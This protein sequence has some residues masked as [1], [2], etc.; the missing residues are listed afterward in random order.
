MN[1]EQALIAALGRMQSKMAK[2]RKHIRGLLAIRQ[3][4]AES[5]ARLHRELKDERDSKAEVMRDRDFVMDANKTLREGLV[6]GRAELADI[7]ELRKDL[8]GDGIRYT[9]K[10]LNDDVIERD[11]AIRALQ[12]DA[13]RSSDMLHD[14]HDLIEEAITT[15]IYDRE[16]GGVIPD[17]DPY[18]V[19]VRTIS[20]YLGIPKEH[21]S[22]FA[23]ATDQPQEHGKRC[24]QRVH[25]AAECDCGVADNDARDAE[26]A[27]ERLNEIQQKPGLLITG[28]ALAARLQALEDVAHTAAEHDRQD[29]AIHMWAG[30][31]EALAKT[32][33]GIQ[34]QLT[35]HGECIEQIEGKLRTDF[36]D[37]DGTLQVLNQS[38]MDIQRRALTIEAKLA[39]MA[40]LEVVVREL[41]HQVAPGAVHAISEEFRTAWNAISTS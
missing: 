8:D 41:V 29:E 10:R 31:L 36:E 19:M 21:A 5:I 35:T 26:T 38:I 27:R 30:R 23:K 16:S 28:D 14:A 20:D 24:A 25:G 32:V 6:Q 18:V 34:N 15:H 13:Q 17:D 4:Q 12:E 9:I 2:Q 22:P 39:R 33:E 3:S 7:A 11:R 1:T 40:Q 37:T